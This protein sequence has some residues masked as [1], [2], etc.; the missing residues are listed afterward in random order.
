MLNLASCASIVPPD[1]PA[2]Y[3]FDQN[4]AYYIYTISNKEGWVDNDKNL[5]YDA[6]FVEKPKKW[7]EIKVKSLTVP[8]F[9][10]EPLNTF[11]SQVCEKEGKKC[12]ENGN[13]MIKIQRLKKVIQMQGE[14][15]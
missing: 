14:V 2:F 9:S 11:I 12:K 15:K 4:R 10:W 5:F 8:S 6:N 13:P 1:V 3:E 7:S